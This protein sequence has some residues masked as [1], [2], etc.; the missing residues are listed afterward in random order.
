MAY[1]E[2]LAARIRDILGDRDDVEARR[3]FGGL[4]FL[5]RSHMA[6]GVLRNELMLRVGPGNEAAALALPH[7]RPMDFTGRPMAGMLWVAP[8]G[9]RTEAS[10]RA[11]VERG[12]AFVATLPARTKVA[13]RPPRI[14]VAKPRPA[15]PRG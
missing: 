2:A 1:D 14:A 7:A 10:L 9:L 5:V 15:K 11:W 4:A 3:M 13:T 6:C 12:L 8:D